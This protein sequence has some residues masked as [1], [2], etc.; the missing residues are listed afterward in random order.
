M[1]LPIAAVAG[2][3]AALGLGA[4]LALEPGLLGAQTAGGVSGQAFGTYVSLI[5]TSLGRTPYAVLPSGGNIATAEAPSVSVP[6]AAEAQNLLAVTSGADNADAPTDA[7][8]QSSSTLERVNLLNGAVSADLVMAIASSAVHG[9]LVNSNA[10]GSQ[11]ANLVVAGTPIASDVAPNT[12]INVPGVGTVVLNE[13]L[14]SGDGVNSTGLT[15]N[16]IHVLVK[17]AL[18][19]LTTGEIIVGSATSYVAR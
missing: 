2:G 3:L 11:F 6:G 17:D 15:V 16:M 7:S 8:A 14:W 5:G 4:G 9:T 18:T 1:K 12:R 10:D 19:G 13:Q